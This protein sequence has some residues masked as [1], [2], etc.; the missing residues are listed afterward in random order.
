MSPIL[1]LDGDNPPNSCFQPNA[2]GDL[3]TCTYVDGHW[4]RSF[5]GPGSGNGGQGHG[6]GFGGHGGGFGG[7]FG[8]HGG[9]YGGGGGGGGHGG[10]NH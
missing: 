4:H 9:G 1:H 7:G 6:G 5:D 3:P 8:G 10:G 2:T